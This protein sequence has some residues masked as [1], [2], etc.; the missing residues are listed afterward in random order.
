M[1]DNYIRLA[2]ERQAQINAA[3]EAFLKSGGCVQILEGFN[4]V[5]RHR[6]DWID[7][8]TVLVRKAPKLS[9]A[10]RKLLQDL[11][12]ELEAGK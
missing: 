10:E 6:T 3:T 11:A 2:S 4:P 9:R 12:N 7:P 5:M 8:E 1:T